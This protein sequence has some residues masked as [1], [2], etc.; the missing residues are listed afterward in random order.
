[1]A[2][3]KRHA[4]NGRVLRMSPTSS[5]DWYETVGGTALGRGDRGTFNKAFEAMVGGDYNQAFE[6][7]GT[8]SA[9]GSKTSQYYLGTMYL[10]GMGALQDYCRAH[11]WL[12]IASSQGHRKS[13]QK[14]ERLTKKMTA[15]QVAEA[16]KLARAW[17]EKHRRAS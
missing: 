8:L 13:R 12:N 6:G 14:L 9:K 1:M 7:F 17:A 4:E 3:K 5:D 11:M 15:N 10:T 16:Q 2:V